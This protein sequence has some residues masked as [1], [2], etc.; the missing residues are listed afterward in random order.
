MFWWT[1]PTVTLIKAGS[2]LEPFELK[3]YENTIKLLSCATS[4]NS[5]HHAF[6][7]L[8]WLRHCHCTHC[9]HLPVAGTLEMIYV[10]RWQV[11]F[12]PYNWLCNLRY[13]LS[14]S[15]YSIC[16]PQ[17]SVLTRQCVVSPLRSLIILGCSVLVR[18]KHKGAVS[19]GGITVIPDCAERCS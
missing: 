10:V 11:F 5:A 15:S 19:C 12:K 8:A 7:S 9:S 2:G 13:G 3:V 16:S 14:L 1:T 6:P 17:S 18:R 4:S